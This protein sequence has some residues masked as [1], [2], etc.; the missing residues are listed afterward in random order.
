[1]KSAGL[2]AIV[3]LV[4]AAPL[5]GENDPAKKNPLAALPSKPGAHVAKI[6]ALGDNQWLDLG[7][8]KADPKWGAARGRSWGGRAFAHAADL[9]GAFFCG[10]G[11][12]AY[13]KPNG[14]YMDDFWFYDVNA[15]RWI[16]LYPGANTKTLKLKLDKN[17]F[18][19]NEKGE[20]VPVSY[21]SHANSNMVYNPHLRK[22]MI[23]W[24]NC[25]WWPGPLPQRRTWLDQSDPIV[26][27]QTKTK[28]GGRVGPVIAASKHPLYWDVA[29][30]KWERRFC[31]GDGPN[32]KGSRHTIG[33]AEYIPSMEK[34]VFV[35]AKKV[36]LYDDGKNS[37][38]VLSTDT[39]KRR[40]GW[41]DNGCYDTKR[42]HLY[43]TYQNRTTFA[44]YEFA[45]RTWKDIKGK[46]Q[47]E[48]LGQSNETCMAYDS[49]NDVLLWHGSGRGERGHMM[50]Y[51]PDANSWT[52]LERTF[53]DKVRTKGKC[54]MGFYAPKLNAHF[55]YLA[56]DSGNKGAT[57]LAYRYK[58]RPAAAR[59]RDR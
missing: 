28:R 9:E 46:N 5:A 39:T 11:V 10:T 1:M 45:T 56:G 59:G 20:F 42:R 26:R 41:W 40:G 25:P 30:G 22:L 51:E 38:S 12:H 49:A 14:H 32:P 52:A 21:L 27:Q 17:G 3:L 33:V 50:V 19:V 7:A 15:H 24:L 34:V 2:S 4:G 44:R 6:K 53:P 13:V 29:G 57:M 47:P 35:T 31:P 54:L 48:K 36:W 18:E 43:F 55:Y 8:P 58:R 16:C 37:W 23:V